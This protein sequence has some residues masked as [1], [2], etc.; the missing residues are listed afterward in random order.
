MGELGFFQW[1]DAIA[2]KGVGAARRHFGVRAQAVWAIMADE[3]LVDPID[4]DGRPGH[5]PY[6]FL[7][8]D[9]WEDTAGVSHGRFGVRGDQ[10][11]L[12]LIAGL[13][14]ELAA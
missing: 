8:F 13:A 9:R 7:C 12:F 14:A 10:L 1:H 6:A 11:A 5:T 2:A 4:G 3:G